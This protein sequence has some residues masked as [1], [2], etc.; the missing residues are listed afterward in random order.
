[1]KPGDV[2][3]IDREELFADPKTGKL[4]VNCRVE[5]Y[6]IATLEYLFM[7]D[8]PFSVAL[9]I[10]IEVD[11]GN[12]NE[13]TEILVL[14]DS[15]SGTYSWVSPESKYPSVN[16]CDIEYY[17]SSNFIAVADS[18]ANLDELSIMEKRLNEHQM[19]LTD[20]DEEK[21]KI[22]DMLVA[23]YGKDSSEYNSDHED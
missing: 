14:D 22:R 18:A 13:P 20:Y 8:A 11:P 12:D 6:D 17:G 2:R 1:M 16:N 23:A 7:N 19:T 4:L 21:Q 3:Y 5:T 15:L 9:L 10:C